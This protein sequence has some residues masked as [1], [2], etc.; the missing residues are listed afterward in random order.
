MEIGA[1]VNIQCTIYHQVIS[2]WLSGAIFML[3]LGMWSNPKV[4]GQCVTLFS[5]FVMEKLSNTRAIVF[6]GS[7]LDAAAS[8]V[9]ILDI[10]ILINTVVRI[11]FYVD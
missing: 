7:E 4:D 6:G 1:L 11:I 8:S 2:V 3:I 9:F 10:S 5:D